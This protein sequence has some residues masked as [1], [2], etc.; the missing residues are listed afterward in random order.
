MNQ[1]DVKIVT[2][3]PMRVVSFYGFG[4]TPEDQAHQLANE[5]LEKNGL[6]QEDKYRHFGFNNPDPTHGSPNYG[7]EIWI[8]PNQ[9]FTSTPEDKIIQFD[10]GLYATTYCPGLDVIGQIWHQLVSWRD[11]SGYFHSNH[12][13]LEELHTPWQKNETTFDFTLYL[14]IKK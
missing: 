7:Y 6:N 5:W 12:Q 10:G 3:P 2:L 11:T 14:P 13:W 4:T 9:D 1:L 8:A